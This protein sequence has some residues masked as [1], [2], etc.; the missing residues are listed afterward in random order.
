MTFCSSRTSGFGECSVEDAA[1][2]EVDHWLTE[3]TASSWGTPTTAGPIEVNTTVLQVNR[4]RQKGQA[5]ERCEVVFAR[6]VFQ[7]LKHST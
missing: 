2:Q 6:M 5:G 7:Q 4:S 1:L 3:V